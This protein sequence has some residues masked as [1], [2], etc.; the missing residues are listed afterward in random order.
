MK[1][2]ILRHAEK[3]RFGLVGVLNTATDFVLLNILAVAVG[4]PVVLANTISSGLC[5]M[6]SFRL[7]K[8]WTFRAAGKNYFREVVLFFVFTIIGVWVIGNGLMAWLVPIMPT[9]WSE[10]IRVSLPKVVATVAS[11]I[12]NFV[13]Y[14]YIVFRKTADE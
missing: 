6:M 9:D 7:N 10:I 2:I 8:K 11:L 3:I 4:L 12:W 1:K 5:M 13:T 14:K